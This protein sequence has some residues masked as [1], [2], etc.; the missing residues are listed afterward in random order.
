MRA[1]W[2]CKFLRQTRPRSPSARAA[3]V[4]LDPHPAPPHLGRMRIL[5]A[6]SGGVDS[7]TVAGLLAEAGHEV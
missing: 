4:G 2:P 3:T 6:M 7:A 1:E 5:V